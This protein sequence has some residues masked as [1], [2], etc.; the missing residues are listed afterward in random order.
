MSDAAMSSVA[1]DLLDEV[2]ESH[3]PALMF[4]LFSGG[5]DSLTAVTIAQEWAAKRKVWLPVAHVNTG[6]GIR[7]TREFVI[8]T[9]QTHGWPLIEL[10]PPRSYRSLVLEFG[11]PGPG[12]HDRFAYPRLKER[13]FRNLYRLAPPERLVM[14]I[15]GVR[16][17]E[18]ER[19]TEHVER[20][21]VREPVVWAAPIW[22]WAKQ[23]CNR[24]IAERGLKRNPVAD[25]LHLSGECLCGA[26]AH[27]GELEEIAEWFPEKAAEIRHLEDEVEAAGLRGC[28]WGRR[29]PRRIAVAQERA[30][31][32]PSDGSFPM[33]CAG[34]RDGGEA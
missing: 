12:Y 2:V 21:Q 9:A 28:R 14:F 15:T 20:I 17:Q 4:A 33:L 19:R 30:F 16:E 8:D 13:C 3:N 31:L 5:H 27:K 1:E 10:H 24:F 6:T 25:L 7:E 18:S 32:T 22:D 11:F 23:D 29:P 34:C 26:M